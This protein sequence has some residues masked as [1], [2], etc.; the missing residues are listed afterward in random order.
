LLILNHKG[1]KKNSGK[2]AASLHQLKD[3]ATGAAGIYIGKATWVVDEQIGTLLHNFCNLRIDILDKKPD[4]MDA[5]S[6]FVDKPGLKDSAFRALHELDF[7]RPQ[8]G[9]RHP[10]FPRTTFRVGTAI[11][12]EGP[13][14]DTK[15]SRPCLNDFV[16]VGYGV[17]DVIDRFKLHGLYSFDFLYN[18]PSDLD[19]PSSWKA[20]FSAACGA[21]LFSQPAREAACGLIPHPQLHLPGRFDKIGARQQQVPEVQMGA[22]KTAV[23]GLSRREFL[24]MTSMAAAGL[25]TG[26]AINP[27]TGKSQFMIMDENQEIAVDRQHS[28]HQLSTDYGIVQDRA[29]ASY[30]QTAGK[31]IAANTHRSHMPYQFH[32]VNANYVNAY[33]FPGGTIACT[34]GILLELENEAALAALLGHELGHVN[35]RHTASIMSRAQLASLAVGGLAALTGA[36]AGAGAGNLAGQLGQLGSGALLASYSRDNER[37]ADSLGMAYMTEAGYGPQGMVSL[38]EM[39]NNMNRRQ[40]GVTDL[41][42]ATHPMSSERYET[43]VQQATSEYRQFSDRPLHRERYLDSIANLRKIKGAI[44]RMQ[45]GEEAMGKEQFSQAEG[46]FRQALG[47]VPDDY[48]GLLLMAKSQLLQDKLVEA[49]RYAERAKQV[50]PDE[51]QAYHISGIAHIRNKKYE[52]AHGDFANYERRLP[53]NPN[54]VFLKGLSLEGMEKIEPAAR[55][56]NDYLKQVQQGQQAQYAYQRLKAWGYIK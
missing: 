34:R 44:N 20:M 56:Y 29:L 4:V 26:C 10:Y 33:A 25:A 30:I 31:R 50:Y 11:F 7:D 15:Q 45:E 32:C 40:A 49:G 42:F 13:G 47:Q 37:Q 24:V 51:A 21:R 1:V 28:P 53:G 8:V 3:G 19:G 41:L 27:V 46:L 6:P 36:A 5:F 18:F 22:P 55:A 35:A 12:P 52:A 16:Y 9:K 17:A 54:T 14:A 2:S 38:M 39:L 43:S 23:N 48:T